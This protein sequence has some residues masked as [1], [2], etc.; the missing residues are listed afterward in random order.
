MVV[1]LG[2]LLFQVPVIAH[3]ENHLFEVVI[4]LG[5]LKVVISGKLTIRDLTRAM[6]RTQPVDTFRALVCYL[7]PPGPEVLV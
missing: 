7:T 3:L 2:S 4:T 1:A 6:N 5:T